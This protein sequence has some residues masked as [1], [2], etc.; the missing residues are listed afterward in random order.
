MTG[1]ATFHELCIQ[2][3][4]KKI[5]Q[6]SV[7]NIRAILWYSNNSFK[8]SR[9][10]DSLKVRSSLARYHWCCI[11]NDPLHEALP[12]VCPLFSLSLY[13][14]YCALWPRKAVVFPLRSRQT[15]RS[16]LVFSLCTGTGSKYSLD[17][18]GRAKNIRFDSG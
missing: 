18:H 16:A 14:Y 17:A 12:S 4:M 5:L 3:C 8:Y 6:D 7:T 10:S 11:K 2:K 9:A 15:C 1:K 13:I